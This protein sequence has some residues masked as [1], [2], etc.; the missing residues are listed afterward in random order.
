MF[1]SVIP[2]LK[3]PFGHCFFDYEMQHGDVH[4]GD[5]I[6]VPFRNQ[7]IAGL[8][9]KKSPN[10]EWAGKAIKIDSPQKIAKLPESIADF[11][12][13]SAS[14]SFV[15]PPTMLNAWIRTVPKRFNEEA[16]TTIRKTTLPKDTLNCEYRYLIDRYN[17]PLGILHTTATNQAN[18]RILVLTPWKRRA[19]YLAAKLGVSAL[20]TDVAYGAAWRLWIDFLNNPHGI[21]ITTRLGAW[22]AG[23]ADVVIIDEPENDDFKQDELTPRYDARRIVELA[24]DFNPAMRTI[25]IGTTPN[26]ADFAVNPTLAESAP[27]IESDITF[28]RL[29]PKNRSPL[30]MLTNEAFIAMDEAVSNNT[31]VRILHTVLGTRG[32]VRCA[33]C[34]WLLECADCHVSLRNML[35]HAICP[36]CEKQSELPL[37]C[38]HCGSVNLSKAIIGCDGLNKLCQS[39]FPN[40]DI[41]V[42]DLHEWI[43]QPIKQGSLLIVSNIAYMGGYAEDIRKKERL[44]LAIRRF[45]SQACVAKCKLIFQ[46]QSPLIDTAPSWLNPQGLAK[47]WEL[48]INDRRE[49]LYPPAQKICK[50]IQLGKPEN[51]DMVKSKLQIICEQKPDWRFR[52]PYPI[53]NL[54]KTREPRSVFHV[55]PPNTASRNDLINELSVLTAYGIVDLDPIAF[56]C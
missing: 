20:H 50:L 51:A 44:V 22:L 14:E 34:D 3:M 9:A 8:V 45:A 7:K 27:L 23:M 13:Q 32:R 42:L 21:L 38:P 43:I 47:Q 52:G 54:S 30:E 5:L 26:L 36:R 48:E 18:G 49:F 1:I 41:K 25:N 2:A 4:V 11:C 12:I 31:P 40:A 55:L 56:F 6:L 16:H 19:D 37:S 10:S 46:G 39:R 29:D 17:D 28:A 53:E 15:S 35:N 33:D 24:R